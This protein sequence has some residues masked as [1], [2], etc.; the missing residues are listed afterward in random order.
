M[1]HVN[2]I[3]QG[4]A[5]SQV[6]RAL[7]HCSTPPKAINVS[8]PETISIRAL[9]RRFAV[10]MEKSVEVVGHEAPTAWLVNT[11]RA[12]DLFGYPEVPLERMTAWIADWVGRE[13]PTLEKPT[14]FEARDG[15]Y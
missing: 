14:H 3:W 9:A 10:L 6:L 13:L 4:D 7:R 5:N 11:G 15:S 8:G 12:T 1:G 2:V